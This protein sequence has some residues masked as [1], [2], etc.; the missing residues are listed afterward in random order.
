MLVYEVLEGMVNGAVWGNGQVPSFPPPR[1][2]TP[3]PFPHTP[4]TYKAIFRTR[5]ASWGV[6]AL[7]P[8][9]G[10]LLCVR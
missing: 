10:R 4:C 6:A 8:C 9:D 2:H 7:P 5:V 3:R 1:T